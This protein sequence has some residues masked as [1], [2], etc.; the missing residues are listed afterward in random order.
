VQID[1]ATG[2]F[3]SPFIESMR[4]GSNTA[5]NS[6]RL[7]RHDVSTV[8]QFK[9]IMDTCARGRSLSKADRERLGIRKH[10][11]TPLAAAKPAATVTTLPDDILHYSEPRILTAREN[12]RLQTFPDTFQFLGKYTTGGA[13]R[14]FDC[15]RY[16][17]IGNAV[18]PLFAEAVGRVLKRLAS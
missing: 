6:L 5:P 9:A 17:Q 11:L 10:A 12:A 18:P 1:Y 8:K 13:N 16:T 4:K 7:P 2:K 14:K 15:P 3:R